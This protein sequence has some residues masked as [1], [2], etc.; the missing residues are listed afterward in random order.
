[1]NTGRTIILVLLAVIFFAAGGMLNTKLL[2]Y[3]KA[4]SLGATELL[5]NSPP[6]VVF[7]TVVLGGFRGL[8]ADILWVR[9]SLLQ[10]EGKYFELVQL[11]EWI[12]IL[13]PR[14]PEVWAFHSWNLAFN[15]SVMM[16]DPEDR[17]RWVYNGIR[18]LRDEGIKYNP[19]VPKLYTELGWLFQ[20]KIGSSI[21]IAHLYYKTRWA[22]EM[23]QLLG[24]GTPDINGLNPA[25]KEKMIKEYGLIPDVMKE[26]EGIFGKLDW[27]LPETHAIYWAYRGQKHTQNQPNIDCDRMIF[28]SLTMLVRNGTLVYDPQTG[29]YITRPDLNLF[30]VTV[31]IYEDALN[32][33]QNADNVMAAYMNFLKDVVLIAPT[34]NQ[35]HIAQEAFDKIKKNDPDSLKASDLD[36]AIS[37]ITRNRDKRKQASNPDISP[38]K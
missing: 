18:L 5:D 16:P 26:V 15:I 29:S 36:S 24:S 25:A 35:R 1:M 22:Y 31:R 8:I 4:T 14:F 21:D 33:Y 30:G 7:T 17:W 19:N 28:Q 34:E 2:D 20:F 3:R 12:T 9:A 11:A 6:G 13:E 38:R 32:K 10:D 23:T 37:E 27:R